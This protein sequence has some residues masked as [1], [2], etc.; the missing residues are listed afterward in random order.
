MLT[1]YFCE[2]QTQD[3]SIIFFYPRVVLHD[4]KMPKQENARMKRILTQINL[5]LPKEL[6]KH[7]RRSNNWLL[8][9]SKFI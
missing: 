7:D 5:A 3:F 1:I 2:I 9:S 4:Q 6:Q 8:L